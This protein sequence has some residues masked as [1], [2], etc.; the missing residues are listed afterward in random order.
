MQTPAL[1][2][3]DTAPLNSACGMIL[4][5][6][7][8]S[9]MDQPPFDRSPLDGYALRA[10]D[11]AGASRDSPV[12]LAVDYKLNAG[13]TPLG[14]IEKGHAAQVMTGA[15]LPPGCDCV[16]RKEETDCGETHVNIYRPLARH[17]NYCFRGEDFNAGQLLFAAETKLNSAALG[18][19]SGLGFINVP[20]KRRAKIALIATGDE[21]FEP[22]VGETLPSG[23]IYSSNLTLLHTRLWE[24]GFNV[25]TA[26]HI[27]DDPQIIAKQIDDILQ[28]ADIVI[29]TGGVSVGE[30]DSL[31]AAMTLLG[32]MQV[33]HGVDIKPGTHALFSCVRDK[34]ILSLSGNPFAAAATF[35]LLARPLLA[36]LNSD[37]S[38]SPS[39]ALAALDMP[40]SNKSS[41]RRFLRGR[42]ENGRVTLPRGHSSGQLLSLVD[43]NCLVEIAADTQVN[44]GD[45]VVVYLF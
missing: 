22:K 44:E 3:E 14:R 28:S 18:V 15:M 42:L 4:A 29:T 6:N 45:L 34:P 24:L 41:M 38:L 36:A 23:K 33:F 26:L 17:E 2:G 16:I 43:C 19:L 5:Q 20:V 37:P 9:N 8:V 11:T 40:Y 25:D 13:D 1:E 39:K 32:A 30:R 7:I 27:G 21:L 10:K 35:E 12:T 31:S